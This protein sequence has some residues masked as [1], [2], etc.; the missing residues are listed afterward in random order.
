MN[1][2]IILWEEKNSTEPKKNFV[3]KDVLETNDTIHSIEEKFVKK[4]WISI[5]KTKIKRKSPGQIEVGKKYNNLTPIELCYL[6]SK[7]R[8]LYKSKCDCGNEKII[9][10]HLMKLGIIKSCGCLHKKQMLSKFGKSRR[11]NF[12]EAA[13]NNLYRDYKKGAKKRNL[14]FDIPID[15]FSS[16]VKQNCHYCN[17]SPSNT[18]YNNNRYFGG[19]LS[20]GIDRIDSRKG[21]LINNVVPCCCKCNRS[22]SDMTLEEFREWVNTVYKTIILKDL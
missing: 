20:N 22:K 16:L 3:N 8:K 10:G 7:G 5:G 4:G 2:E 18:T 17:A 9:Y 14:I 13:L 19:F 12:G 15:I 1:D 6:D 11:K 21:Y